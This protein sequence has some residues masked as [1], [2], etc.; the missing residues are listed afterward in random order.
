MSN[1]SEPG[2]SLNETPWDLALSNNSQY[3]LYVLW[4][5]I[6]QPA[7]DSILM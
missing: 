1:L 6:N 3:Q 2:K 7:H 5:K 4:L